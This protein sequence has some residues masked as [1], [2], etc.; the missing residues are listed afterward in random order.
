MLFMYWSQQKIKGSN[1]ED[2]PNTSIIQGCV[3]VAGAG[4]ILYDPGGNIIARFSWGPGS[5]SNNKVE[6]YGLFAGISLARSHMVSKLLI[7]NDSMLIIR[8]I[9]NNKNIG[10]NFLFGTLLHSISLLKDFEYFLLFHVKHDLNNDAEKLAK[11]RSR[12][13]KG[14]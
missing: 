6:A 7:F 10:G 13:A 12:L 2:Y 9:I 14:H 4:G 11:E 1:I 5:V 8:A 3:G